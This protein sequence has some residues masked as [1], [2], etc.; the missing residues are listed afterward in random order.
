MI[1][2]QGVETEIRGLRMKKSKK[3]ILYLLLLIALPLALIVYL[4]EL[5]GLKIISWR[6]R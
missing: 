6:R 5:F 2:S 3:S 4:L 1:F